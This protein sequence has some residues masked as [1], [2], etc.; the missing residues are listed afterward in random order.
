MID[1]PQRLRGAGVWLTAPGGSGRR[2]LAW[3][4]VDGARGYRIEVRNNS[5]GEPVARLEASEPSTTGSFGTLA[6]GEYEA[7][8]FAMD[9]L[10]FA[11]ARPLK[12][13]IRVIS[14]TIPAGGYVDER[15]VIR[16]GASQKLSVSGIDGVEMTY[17][18]NGRFFRARAQGAV[19]LYRNEPTLVNFRIQGTHDVSTI[20]LA[21][22]TVRA[23]V[24]VG[25]KTVT[26]PAEPVE[27]RIQ[28]VDPTGEPIPEWLEVVPRVTLGLK[29]LN[30]EFQK[31]GHVL[32]GRVPPQPGAGPW[33]VRVDVS[34]QFGLPLGR[35]FVEVIQ[36]ASKPG[37]RVA[38]VPN[39]PRI[40][41]SSRLSRQA[42]SR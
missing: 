42:S 15:D 38:A 13:A 34:D 8:V 1:A 17:G 18:R 10:G 28:L 20:K 19:G 39:A 41:H 21:P 9:S 24:S 25:P 27:I 26:W 29:Q 12:A 37:A 30:V 14:A 3:D 16:L 35:D 7:S 5:D 6:P 32:H 36:G 31:K 11:S 23:R 40:V 2:D 33:V 4:P 22:R